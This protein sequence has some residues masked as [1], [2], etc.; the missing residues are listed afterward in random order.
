MS[1]A[2]PLTTT[3]T[4]APA[5]TG[6]AAYLRIAQVLLIGPLGA[7]V[8]FGSV[9]FGLIAPT[10]DSYSVLDWS[11]G[12]WAFVMGVTSMVLGSRLRSGG[13]RVQRAAMA[14]VAL[15]IVFGVVKLTVYS[16]A[17]A[18]TFMAVDAIV[19]GL[20]ARTSRAR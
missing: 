7:L 16:E 2:S 5:D 3:P 9:Y 11:V 17:E 14:L 20:L 12:A 6:R 15:H 1:T 13:P 8:V 18:A 19:L 4:T 10:E